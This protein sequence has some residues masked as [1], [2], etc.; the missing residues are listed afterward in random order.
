[1]NSTR[2]FGAVLVGTAAIAGG[3]AVCA[4]PAS[5]NIACTPTVA[6][7]AD[8]VEACADAGTYDADPSNAGLGVQA[9]ASVEII[10]SGDTIICTGYYGA[11]FNLPLSP[12]VKLGQ[13]AHTPPC[14]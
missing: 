2:K 11:G 5:A 7:G 8:S 6:V 12:D 3:L 10:A 9:A 4:A 13:G 1:M 14:S